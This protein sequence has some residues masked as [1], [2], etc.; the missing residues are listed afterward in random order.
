MIISRFFF[1]VKGKFEFSK[2]NRDFI[3][4]D[5]FGADCKLNVYNF[6]RLKID[7]A[8]VQVDWTVQE[9]RK[10]CEVTYYY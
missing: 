1:V 4:A 7:Q 2:P 6:F 3:S 9:S 5:E 10:T 8:D